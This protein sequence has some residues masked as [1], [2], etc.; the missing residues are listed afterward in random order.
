MTRGPPATV[1]RYR[2]RALG[3]LWL[4]QLVASLVFG[5]AIGVGVNAGL[6][7]E[8]VFEVAGAGIKHVSLPIL[9]RTQE[10]GLDLSIGF[11]LING[12]VAA[13][14]WVFVFLLR[15][16]DPERP[17]RW[18]RRL[19]RHNARDPSLMIFLPFRGF[20]SIPAPELRPLFAR[21]VALPLV[22]PLT[23]GAIFGAVIADGIDPAQWG[24]S[25]SVRLAMV[26]P[27]AVVEL[28]AVFLPLAVLRA[29]YLQVREPL[30]AG[31]GDAVWSVL[32]RET[33]WAS[34]APLVGA[35]GIGIVLAAVIEAH[36][37]IPIA[38]AVD[39]LGR[40]DPPRSIVL[41]TVD[42][43]VEL[44]E[45]FLAEGVRFDPGVAPVSDPVAAQRALHTGLHPRTPIPA[46]RPTLA[47]VARERG[48]RTAA[49]VSDPRLAPAVLELEGF[50]VERAP[51]TV[52]PGEETLDEAIAW[53]EGA[54]AD[55]FLVWIHLG[56]P[57]P[58]E[59][60]ALQAR[61]LGA[62][63]GADDPPL[64]TLIAGAGTPGA[65]PLARSALEI[66]WAL[67][68]GDRL[69]AGR[70]A[71]G[72]ASAID[73]APTLLGLLWIRGLGE[74]GVMRAGSILGA[75]GMGPGPTLAFAEGPEGRRHVVR[76]RRLVLHRV[77]G[78][79]APTL[80]LLDEDPGMETDVAG[81][82]PDVYALL[83]LELDAWLERTA[84]PPAS[85]TPGAP[86][87]SPPG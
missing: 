1:A 66:P 36:A 14:L 73:V 34:V 74:E 67:W 86:A 35:T 71:R 24:V 42:R 47:G 82:H 23:L 75:P 32:R 22:G 84:T 83:A 79:G 7:P 87:S 45:R 69:P 50:D 27:H 28:T 46:G 58:E 59:A 51:G 3:H 41:V 37:T 56:A 33:G 6:E 62:V 4:A 77:E 31:Q 61:L 48:L 19:R 80:H 60:R 70:A 18:S 44:D 21:L 52:R 29:L 10:E 64:V 65:D 9:Q 55:R 49:F 11:V 53:L 15:L 30:E 81:N 78:G 5:A 76:G 16:S 13:L 63:A 68:W 25:L 12:S 17:G 2:L 38:R 85:G 43:P 20:R 72:P 54:V 8:R 39:A 57:G 26:L 40:G